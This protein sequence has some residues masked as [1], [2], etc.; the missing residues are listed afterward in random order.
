MSTAGRHAGDRDEPL[1]PP[2]PA[3]GSGRLDLRQS[4]IAWVAGGL[5]GLLVAAVLIALITGRL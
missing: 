3:H 4:T 5:V 1:P 2:W